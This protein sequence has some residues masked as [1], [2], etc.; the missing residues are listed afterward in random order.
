MR[1]LLTS[2]FLLAFAI[3]FAAGSAFAADK[4]RVGFPSLATALSPPWVAAKK[5]FWKKHGL[6]VELI[7]L[8]GRIIISSLLGG[9][10]DIVIG[11]DTSTAIANIKGANIVRLGVTTNSLGSSLVSQQHVSSF[12]QL[13]DKTIGIGSRGFSS[14][15]LR[16]SK[17]L[18]DNGLE[19]DKDVKFFPIGGGPGARVAALKKNLVIAAMI[20]PPYDLVAAE[21][22]MKIF[23]KIDAPVIAGGVN[24]NSDYLQGNRDKLVRFLKGYIEGIHFLLTN[25]EETIKV[26]SDYLGNRDAKVLSH[27]YDEIAGRAEKDLRPDPD[28][29]RFTLDFIG[30]LYPKAKELKVTD[31]SDLSLLGEIEKSGF[32]D[33]LYSGT[34]GGSAN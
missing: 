13:K 5:G 33:K 22:G 3:H 8:S 34:A 19:P 1:R 30:R 10:L 11:S 29:V 14:L 27:F 20:T 15:E 23:A 24:V 12:K 18:L 9:D 21:S 28:S 2:V 6:D 31:Y 25:K 17:L 16:L 7:F 26:F 32:I 4:L